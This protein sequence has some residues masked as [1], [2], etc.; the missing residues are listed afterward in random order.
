MFIHIQK[1]HPK[2]RENFGYPPMEEENHR[3]TCKGDFL[4]P[5][6]AKSTYKLVIS[7]HLSMQMMTSPPQKNLALLEGAASTPNIAQQ[8][9]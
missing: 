2:Y 9:P 3:A 4:V 6:R 8:G 1:S 7:F 5:W